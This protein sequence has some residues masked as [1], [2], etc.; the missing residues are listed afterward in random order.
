[1]FKYTF[2]ALVLAVSLAGCGATQPTTSTLT[3]TPTPP[4]PTPTPVPPAATDISVADLAQHARM[5]DCWIV[6]NGSVYDITNYL[7]R[8]P[9]GPGKMTPYC[10]KASGI[11]AA[12]TDQH[13]PIIGDQLAS[14][15][16]FKG[17][18]Q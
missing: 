3:T 14:V 1:M 15:A 8:H 4:T 5:T 7:P 13:G 16:I 12:A 11:T 6:F 17:K 9:G 2:M 18:L 10:G